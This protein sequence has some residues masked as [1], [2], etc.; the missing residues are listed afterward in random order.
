MAAKHEYTVGAINSTMLITSKNILFGLPMN[1]ERYCSVLF[2]GA[3]G[4]AKANFN[5]LRHV[6]CFWTFKSWKMVI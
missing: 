5:P 2:V 4:Y 6:H 1:I 3:I